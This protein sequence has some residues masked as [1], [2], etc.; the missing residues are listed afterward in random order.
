MPI[1][2]I[3]STQMTDDTPSTASISFFSAKVCFGCMFS[4]MTIDIPAV[5]KVLSSTCSPCT[6]SS[7]SG[8]YERIS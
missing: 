2:A 7:S 5:L 6:D 8:R 1:S 4:V 3:V